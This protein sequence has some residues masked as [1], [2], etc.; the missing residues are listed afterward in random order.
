MLTLFKVLVATSLVKALEDNQLYTL[1]VLLA[2]LYS[3]C[4]E[5]LAPTFRK[6]L[7]SADT[8]THIYIV[9]KAVQHQVVV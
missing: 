4:P 8:A 7:Q 2:S 5:E 6:L 1:A 3:K 9:C